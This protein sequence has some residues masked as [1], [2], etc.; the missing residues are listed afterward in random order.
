MESLKNDPNFIVHLTCKY[1]GSVSSSHRGVITVC[2]CDEAIKEAQEAY[3][4]KTAITAKHRETK[5][6]FLEVRDARKCS[7]YRRK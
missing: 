5:K 6:T 2:Q 4:R 7:S 1:C 3:G